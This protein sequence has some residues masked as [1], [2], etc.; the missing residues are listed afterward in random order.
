MLI[1]CLL[2]LLRY[3]YYNTEHKPI[4][5][6]ALYSMK[7]NEECIGLGLMCV[8]IFYF[9]CLMWIFRLEG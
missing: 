2:A 5:K 9:K 6:S 3:G 8:I 1:V 7:I 4:V